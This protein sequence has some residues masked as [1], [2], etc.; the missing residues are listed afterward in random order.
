MAVVIEI[1]NVSKKY[2]RTHQGITALFNRLI[3]SVKVDQN[4]NDRITMSEMFALKNISIKINEGESIG[5]IGENGAGKSTL[6]KL[7][8]GIT[9]PTNGSV[10]IRGAIAGYLDILA[11]FHHEYSGRENVF[12]AGAFLGAQK[13]ALQREFDNIVQFAELEDHINIPIKKYSSG[14]CLRLAF[15]IAIHLEHEILLF[16]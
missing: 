16:D 13:K 5:I 4:P 1:E 6:L 7:I 10:K 12:F 14:M 8:Y 15:S 2:Q 11:G 9:T 3:K